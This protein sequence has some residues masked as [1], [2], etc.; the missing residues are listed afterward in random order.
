[1]GQLGLGESILMRK[2]PAQLRSLEGVGL[3]QVAA[4]GMHTVLLSDQGEVRMVFIYKLYDIVIY[5]LIASGVM[6]RE[7]LA[8]SQKRERNICPPKYPD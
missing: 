5:R 4:G 8:E 2:K 1:M 6:T 7:R 3:R